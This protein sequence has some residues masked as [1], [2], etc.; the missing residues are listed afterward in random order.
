MSDNNDNKCV[1]IE[2]NDGVAT[3]WWDMPGRS[4]NVFNQASITDFE[5]AVDAVL[6][7]ASVTGIIVTSAKKDFVAGADLESVKQMALGPKDALVLASGQL[8]WTPTARTSAY[9]FRYAP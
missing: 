1:R 9:S 5:A 4:Q 3:L 6:A 8:L 7:D 2:Q